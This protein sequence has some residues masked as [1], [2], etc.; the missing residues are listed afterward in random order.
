[1]AIGGRFLWRERNPASWIEK[2][3]MHEFICE[4]ADAL[5]ELSAPNSHD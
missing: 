5:F 1:M 4:M 2:L 3:A